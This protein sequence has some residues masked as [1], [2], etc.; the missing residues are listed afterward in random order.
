[1]TNPIRL[2]IA[3][4]LLPRIIGQHGSVRDDVDAALEWA[5]LLIE[6][7]QKKGPGP[8]SDKGMGGLFDPDLAGAPEPRGA[9]M[10]D[11]S[12]WRAEIGQQPWVRAIR[13]IGGK[14]GPNNWPAWEGLI[15]RRFGGDVDACIAVLE[16][17]DPG[18]RWPD[19]VEAAA[20]RQRPTEDQE[21][22]IEL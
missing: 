19:R 1:M 21:G 16:T 4:R 6:A 13:R 15:E 7:D 22:A 17:V 10:D 20:D 8:A 12:R 9:H 3:K 14:I 2:D 5:D 11:A 18:E